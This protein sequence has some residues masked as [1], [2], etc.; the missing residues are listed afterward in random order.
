MWPGAVSPAAKDGDRNAV[1]GRHIV[2][3]MEPN[4]P[5]RQQLRVVQAYDEVG[6][7]KTCVQSVLEHG[8]GALLNLFRRLADHDQRSVPSLAVLC[9]QLGGTNPG[10]HVRVVPAGVH[11]RNGCAGGILR[12]HRAGIRQ[13][14][15]FRHRQGI[16]VGAQHYCRSRPILQHGHYACAPDPGGYVIAKAAHALG[17]F[18]RS[19]FFLKGKLRVAMQVDVERLDRRVNSSYLLG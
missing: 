17:Q 13:S 12:R 8:L 1:T 19:L 11:Y 4:L 16:H 15:L 5:G 10:R 2:A 3:G 14:G 6:L 9:H 18:G 7:G